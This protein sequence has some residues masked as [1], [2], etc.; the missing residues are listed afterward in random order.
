MLEKRSISF[1]PTLDPFSGWPGRWT[2]DMCGMCASC[3]R[4]SP[5]E[6]SA[7]RWKH[8]VCATKMRPKGI[9]ILVSWVS[10]R[11]EWLFLF[12]EQFGDTSYCLNVDK[13]RDTAPLTPRKDGASCSHLACE[14]A[15]LFGRAKRACRERASE[16]LAASP[17]ARAFSRDSL[18]STK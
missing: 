6:G 17:L 5:G 13:F 18:R 7:S 15:L 9:F 2:C 1:L 4:R 12:S 8:E 14:Q 10:S 11:C 16:G 3:L